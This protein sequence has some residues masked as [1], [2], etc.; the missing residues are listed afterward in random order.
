MGA[1]LERFR[2]TTTTGSL[3]SLAL[4]IIRW[5]IFRHGTLRWLL[6]EQ[7]FVPVD[8]RRAPGRGLDR[9]LKRLAPFRKIL[10]LVRIDASTTEILGRDAG[11]VA[12]TRIQ[13]RVLLDI[14]SIL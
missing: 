13:V 8:Q 1:R 11:N 5:I 12:L 4:V 9:V 2:R 10:D 14:F 6:G 3:C 7:V